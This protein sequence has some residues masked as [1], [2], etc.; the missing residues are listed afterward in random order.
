MNFSGFLFMGTHKGKLLQLLVDADD[1][2]VWL[3]LFYMVLYL[4]QDATF[5]H[6][7]LPC[8]HFDNALIDKWSYSLCVYPTI[9]ELYHTY[10]LLVI[11]KTFGKNTIFVWHT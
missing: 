7:A 4:S 5:S 1:V 6:T 10:F 3:C 9:D 8:E 11:L 2:A